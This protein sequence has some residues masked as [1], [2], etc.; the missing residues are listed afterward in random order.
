M[1]EPLCQ[2]FD[3]TPLTFVMSEMGKTDNPCG[4]QPGLDNLV[5]GQASEHPEL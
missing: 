3:N 2:W 1:N 4:A 5:W